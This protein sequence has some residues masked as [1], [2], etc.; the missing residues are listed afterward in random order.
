M[1]GRSRRDAGSID[2]GIEG[3]LS[4]GEFHQKLTWERW[5]GNSLTRST[6]TGQ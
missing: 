4:I 5:S 6:D 3:N 1:R 2:D